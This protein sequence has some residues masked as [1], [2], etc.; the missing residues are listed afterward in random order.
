MPA[1]IQA[2]LTPQT[3]RRLSP[4]THLFPFVRHPKSRHYLGID[5]SPKLWQNRQT[6]VALERSGINIIDP[7]LR[8]FRDAADR[9]VA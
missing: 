1:A 7:R 4:A 2:N 5:F 6:Y 9:R 8:R 3:T